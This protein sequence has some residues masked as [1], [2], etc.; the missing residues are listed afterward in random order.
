MSEG[1]KRLKLGVNEYKVYELNSNTNVILEDGTISLLIPSTSNNVMR[2]GDDLNYMINQW[3]T[4]LT[5]T[6][7][8]NIIQQMWINNDS[9]INLY[10]DS[11]NIVAH[12]KAWTN[13]TFTGFCEYYCTVSYLHS[14]NSVAFISTSSYPP[15]QAGAMYGYKCKIVAPRTLSTNLQMGVIMYREGSSSQYVKVGAPITFIEYANWLSTDPSDVAF[16]TSLGGVAPGLVYDYDTSNSLNFR[17]T[18]SKSYVFLHR[19]YNN[20]DNLSICEY[21]PAGSATQYDYGTIRHEYQNSATISISDVAYEP[22]PIEEEGYVNDINNRFSP[23]ANSH[24]MGIYAIPGMN[25]DMST[26]ALLLMNSDIFDLIANSFLGSDGKEYIITVNHFFGLVPELTAAQRFEGPSDMRIGRRYLAYNDPLTNDG[27]Y[28]NVQNL[29]SE[30]IVWKTPALH[31]VQHF[32]DYRDYLCKYQLFLPYYGYVDIDP[33]DAVAADI[34]VYYNINVVTRGAMIVV[35]SKSFRTNNKETKILSLSTTVGEEIPFCANAMGNA[36]T[37]LAQ[38]TGKAISMGTSVATGSTGAQIASLTAQ[39]NY[40]EK[41]LDAGKVEFK[42]ADSAIQGNLDKMSDLR[43]S[44]SNM[45]AIG[46][47]ASG[48]PNMPVPN[49]A[50]SN[51]SGSETGTVDE[52]HPYI[53]VTR[54]YTC[55]PGDWETYNGLPTSKSLTLSSCS[56][57]TKV[58]AVKPETLTNAPKY[59]DE[60]ISLLQ[61]G[62]YL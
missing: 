48:V 34:K 9:D 21:V 16:T 41:L 3:N 44:Q 13:N 32:N 24:F 50:R 11:S 31:I 38:I 35:T 27:I 10:D 61:A 55:E 2:N 62:V 6:N 1:W 53:L 14:D 33:N 40:N 20:Q 47:V 4:L 60:I 46:N 57:F 18:L 42:S 23:R 30:F 5:S 52:L 54:P 7:Y 59:I 56:G 36:M 15:Y 17:L 45:N 22:T 29:N 51:G 37:A 28:L 19:V 49:T 8:R 43:K 26:F 58:A 25:L 39:N 12:I